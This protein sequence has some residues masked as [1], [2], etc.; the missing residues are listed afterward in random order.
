[1][2]AISS[3]AGSVL[4]I[5][6]SWRI[7][8]DDGYSKMRVNNSVVSIRGP[9]LPFFSSQ[10]RYFLLFFKFHPYGLFAPCVAN[11]VSP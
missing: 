2:A 5:G 8:R 1:M 11:F 10:S 3:L 9:R 4:Q 6:P 7:C